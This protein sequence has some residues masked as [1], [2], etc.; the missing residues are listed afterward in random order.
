MVLLVIGVYFRSS[1]TWESATGQSEQAAVNAQQGLVLFAPGAVIAL[2]GAGTVLF[3]VIGFSRHEQQQLRSLGASPATLLIASLIETL[4]YVATA[5]LI[6][7]PI[8][9]S[10]T[11]AFTAAL[12]QAG[13]D[14]SPALNL[15]AL[16]LAALTGY[17]VTA[18]A[19]APST[20]ATLRGT[21]VVKPAFAS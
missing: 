8:V 9:F 2:V 4:I 5:V 15:H 17:I 14:A 1:R 19:T 13:L 21:T 7:L 20:A 10:I 18:L 16:G 11:A 6:A 12:R 3:S